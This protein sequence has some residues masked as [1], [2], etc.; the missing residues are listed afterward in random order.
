VYLEEGELVGEELQGQGGDEGR[1]GAVGRD[2]D[3]VR[4]QALHTH[5]GEGG[6]GVRRSEM[7][8]GLA[9]QM[10]CARCVWEWV[11]RGVTCAS[12]GLSVMM[13]RSA[14]RACHT[15]KHSIKPG[16]VS[17]RTD[18]FCACCPMAAYLDLLGGGAH[19]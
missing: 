1:E 7:R 8:R 10:R 5:R 13:M 16:M 2:D 9:V 11:V 4:H 14:P 15:S 19:V 18:S 3:G 17:S 12:L 6:E